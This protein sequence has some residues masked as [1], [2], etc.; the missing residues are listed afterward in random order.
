MAVC[1]KRYVEMKSRVQFGHSRSWNCL[2]FSQAFGQTADEKWYWFFTKS[3]LLVTLFNNS[4][5]CFR[6]P[7]H[8]LIWLILFKDIFMLRLLR[9]LHNIYWK[10]TYMSHHVIV[11][12]YLQCISMIS[13]GALL[14]IKSVITFWYLESETFR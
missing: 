14:A 7:S 4:L 2:S 8:F 3:F 9:S 5:H 10:W 13:K 11:K 1:F 12:N 6:W